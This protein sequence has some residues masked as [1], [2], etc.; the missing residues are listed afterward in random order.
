MAAV[1]DRVPEHATAREE[2]AR[3]L[4]AEQPRREEAAVR[5]AVDRAARRV[6]RV[7]VPRERRARERGAVGDVHLACAETT[8]LLS[9]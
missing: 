7:G 6:E 5:A 2:V 4:R 1:D 9:R 3:R 8:V